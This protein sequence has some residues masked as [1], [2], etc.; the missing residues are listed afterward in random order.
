MLGD[1]TGV[2]QL[3]RMDGT[4]WTKTY[5][6]HISMLSDFDKVDH[7]IPIR[8]QFCEARTAKVGCNVYIARTHQPLNTP[9]SFTR[10]PAE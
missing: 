3:E 8:C 5:I 4:I 7:V 2:I 9:P 10:A 1:T 6:N